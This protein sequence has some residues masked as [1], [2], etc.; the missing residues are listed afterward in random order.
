M[1][2][3]AF[4]NQKGGVSKTTC[5]LNV[6]A[7]LAR[8]GKK[9]LL[10]DMDPQGSLTLSAG[11]RLAANDK[12]VYEVLKGKA[13]I[14][15]IVREHGSNEASYDVAPVDFRMS[16][17]NTQLMNTIGKE[18]LLKKALEGVKKKYDYVLID[19]SPSLGL[20]TI[21]TLAAADRYIIPVT[22]QYMPLPGI[23]QLEVTATLVKNNL[24]KKLKLTGII[25]TMY[26]SRRTLDKE[27]VRTIQERYPKNTFRTYIKNNS[28]I[29]EA[30]A[31]GQDI[32][33]YASKFKLNTQL[34]DDNRLVS[35][36]SGGEK[37]KIQL[38]KIMV[39]MKK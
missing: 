6:G 32:F 31:F 27:A 24:N 2:T 37:V 25:V 35:S 7:A 30:P 14:T 12:T 33:E 38:I 10:V 16:D 9:V 13:D 4:V 26:D 20:L 19:S 22:A 28:K 23:N 29:A 39:S 3:I 36:L 15:S 21:M 17:A 1:K 8:A 18:M 5:C 34:L 11:I